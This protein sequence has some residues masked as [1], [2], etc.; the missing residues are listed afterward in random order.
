MSTAFLVPLA[1]SLAGCGEDLPDQSGERLRGRYLV[2]V[3]TDTDLADAGIRVGWYDR[4]LDADCSFVRDTDGVYRCLPDLGSGLRVFPDASC[5]AGEALAVL[6][7]SPDSLRRCEPGYV[8]YVYEDER[9]D[10]SSSGEV[11]EILGP[12][13]A[14]TASHDHVETFFGDCNAWDPLPDATWTFCETRPAPRDRFVEAAVD[15]RQVGDVRQ[16]VLLGA[17]GSREAHRLLHPTLDA[18]LYRSWWGAGV[19]VPDLDLVDR[20]LLSCDEDAL[21]GQGAPPACADA[22]VVRD[23]CDADIRPVRGRGSCEEGCVDLGPAL[24]ALPYVERAVGKDR[25]QPLWIEEGGEPV[26]PAHL[27]F[28]RDLGFVCGPTPVADGREVCAPVQRDVG[29]WVPAFGDEACTEPLGRAFVADCAVAVPT[30]LW[31]GATE[32]VLRL[33]EVGPAPREVY[34]GF[35]MSGGEVYG[36]QPLEAE[37]VTLYD[38]SRAVGADELVALEVVVE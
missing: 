24:P 33:T 6:E 37:G 35:V 18:A 17:D 23:G 21:C 10:R 29:E 2:P 7:G 31:D 8:A 25:L 13:T 22:V 38:E 27:V 9:C 26:L 36:C 15:R 12:S 34:T 4:E 5:D 11:L 1:L 19:L 14:N 20:S 30:F 28:D 32:T 16:E 3:G